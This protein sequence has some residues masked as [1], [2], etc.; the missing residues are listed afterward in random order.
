[1]NKYNVKLKLE[2]GSINGKFMNVEYQINSSRVKK[3]LVSENEGLLD[4]EISLP[5]KVR[6]FFSNKDNATDTIVNESN[7]IVADLYVK[8]LKITLDN[9]DIPQV[10]IQKNLKL[11]TGKNNQINTNYIGFNGTMEIPFDQNS[12]FKQI[13]WFKK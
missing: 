10:Y 2:F 11:V 6:L 12:V 5:G 8:I 4:D 3:V 7:E 1:M 9:F 13:N